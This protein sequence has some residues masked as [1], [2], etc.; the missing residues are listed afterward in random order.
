MKRKVPET[1]QIDFI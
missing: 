1:K